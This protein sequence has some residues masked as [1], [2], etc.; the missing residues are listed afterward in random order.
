VEG[1]VKFSVA[2]CA[3]GILFFIF[4]ACP[5]GAS[6]SHGKDQPDYL[7]YIEGTGTYFLPVPGG[8]IFFHLGRW[9]K[10][11]GDLW[12]TSDR[13]NGPWEGIPSGSLPE[14]LAGLPSDF[15]TSRHLGKI[16]SR[17][18]LGDKRT[19]QNPWFHYYRGRFDKTYKHFGYGK[20][21]RYGK[22]SWIFVTPD[23]RDD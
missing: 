19:C 12:S 7:Y 13:L 9:Y 18:V 1:K 14:D 23:F 6:G 3:A 22:R 5:A 17:Y 2:L 4:S 16:P 21:W 15:R 8:E 11:T 20:R 10:H